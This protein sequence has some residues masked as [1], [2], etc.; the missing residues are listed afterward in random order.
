MNLDLLNT[1]KQKKTVRIQFAWS[2]ASAQLSPHRLYERSGSWALMVPVA[3]GMGCCASYPASAI[4]FQ[5]Q[6][7]GPGHKA[8]QASRQDLDNCC[9]WWHCWRSYQ[10]FEIHRFCWEVWVLLKF[11]TTYTCE[12]HTFEVWWDSKFEGLRILLFWR[13]SFGILGFETLQR[14]PA[15]L[16]TPS[17]QLC[18]T[19]GPWAPR[20]S[21]GG[22]GWPTPTARGSH[23]YVMLWQIWSHDIPTWCTVSP[24]FAGESPL[25]SFH[26]NGFLSAFRDTLQ[27]HCRRCCM[28]GL[29]VVSHEPGCSNLLGVDKGQGED[30]HSYVYYDIV[31]MCQLCKTI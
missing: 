22:L 31:V 1:F 7:S 25:K 3:W 5:C 20:V 21:S 30:M 16:H 27:C 28:L 26:L 15:G 18:S 4:T 12:H 10:S 17:C 2:L 14:H 13:T 9:L 19:S 29:R 6:S 23:V 24:I 11:S 8:L